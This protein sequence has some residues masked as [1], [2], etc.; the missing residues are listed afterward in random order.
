MPE[1]SPVASGEVFPKSGRSLGWMVF[2]GVR[3]RLLDLLLPVH[4]LDCETAMERPADSILFCPDCR[5]ELAPEAAPHCLRCGAT[6]ET[7]AA[8]CVW[9]QGHRLQFDQVIH[10][11][12]YRE[13][14]RDVVLRMKRSMSESLSVSMG[15]LLLQ[16]R[17]ETLREWHADLVVPV[18]MHWQRRFAR[19]ISSS[20]VLASCL[21]KGMGIP[22]CRALAR[23]R[24]TKPQNELRARQRFRNVYGAFGLCS[25]YDLGGAR[26]LLVDDVLTTG[27]TASAAARVLKRA[28]AAAV[29]VAVAARAEGPDSR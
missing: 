7:T 21:A 19:G 16:A 15:R 4:C 9:C 1:G 29:A 28:G 3:L 20:D 2:R 22:L 6:R 23:K 11:G 24:N 17:G 5:S 13:K 27:A 8:T 12:L 25:G 18:P 10:L 14:L 26:V